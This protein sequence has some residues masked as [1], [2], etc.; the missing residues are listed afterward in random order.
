[1]IEN[2]K[3]VLKKACGYIIGKMKIITIIKQILVSIRNKCKICKYQLGGI[4]RHSSINPGTEDWLINTEIK[5][6]G[7]HTNVPRTKVS[8]KD[9]RSEKQLLIGGMIGGDRMLHHG[10]ASNYSKY[11]IPFVMRGKPLT[12]VEIGI[13]KGTGLAIWCE[14]FKNGR[15]LGFDID[16]E[17]I[18]KNMKNLKKIGAFQNNHPELYEFDQFLDNTELIGGLLKGDKIDIC[19]DDGYHSNSSILN[20]MK[21]IIP[22]LADE[23]VYFVEDNKEVHKEIRKLYPKYFIVNEGYLTI[24]SN[25]L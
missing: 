15:I 24:V 10:Y 7:I 20:T 16:L 19:I 2:M 13:L 5:Y 8:P 4:I 23:F 1:M 3:T 6:G 9:P 18:N 25:S 17:H 12:L 11:L 14:L 22:Y 21:N